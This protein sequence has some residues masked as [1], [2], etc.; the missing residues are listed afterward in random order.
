ML[1]LGVS[2]VSAD[3]VIQQIAGAAFKGCAFFLW[4]D[5]EDITAVVGEEGDALTDVQKM[6]ARMRP[7][8]A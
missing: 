1:V 3:P 2:A 4:S 8:E 6:A 5:G 7:F